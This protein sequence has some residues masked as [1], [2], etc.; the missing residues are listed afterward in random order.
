VAR[1][2]D[3]VGLL[4]ARHE[5]KALHPQGFE[6]DPRKYTRYWGGFWPVMVTST[7]RSGCRQSISCRLCMP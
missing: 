3:R 1:V 2:D 6:G 4:C 5:Q 7:R